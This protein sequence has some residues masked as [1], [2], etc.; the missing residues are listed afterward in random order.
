VHIGPTPTAAV[1][2]AGAAAAADAVAHPPVTAGHTR[3]KG[4]KGRGKG[5][6]KGSGG[7]SAGP[8]QPLALNVD[9]PQGH[10]GDKSVVSPKAAPAAGGEC[11][12]AGPSTVVPPWRALRDEYRTVQGMQVRDVCVHV[13]IVL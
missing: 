13:R 12:P 4:G 3:S 11:G 9:H 5:K 7:A 6:G 8:L 10:G 1:G 2:V